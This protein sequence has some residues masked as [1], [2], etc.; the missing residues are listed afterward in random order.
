MP[1]SATSRQA[2]GQAKAKAAGLYKGR[3]EDVERNAG[4][5]MIQAGASWTSIQNATGCSRVTIA[6]QRG[7]MTPHLRMISP[8]D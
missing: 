2:Q 4:I 6:L 1:G 8:H 7:P 3:A 5:A